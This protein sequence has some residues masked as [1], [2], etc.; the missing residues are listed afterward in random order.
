MI[1][2]IS[3]FPDGNFRH[4]FWPVARIFTF[5]PPI[6]IVRTFVAGSPIY[7]RVALF[8]EITAVRS[9]Q[10]LQMTSK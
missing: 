3:V 4:S 10:D 1:S 2:I 9:F 8:D 6:S 7:L 5:V